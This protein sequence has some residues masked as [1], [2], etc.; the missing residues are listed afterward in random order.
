MINTKCREIISIDSIQ[1]KLYED[2]RI[3]LT[4]TFTS[5]IPVSLLGR[6]W[7]DETRYNHRTEDTDRIDSILTSRRDKNWSWGNTYRPLQHK[8]AFQDTR[9]H[10]EVPPPRW[11]TPALEWTDGGHLHFSKLSS[12][13]GEGPSLEAPVA[14]SSRPIDISDYTRLVMISNDPNDD[15]GRRLIRELTIRMIIRRRTSSWNA[16]RCSCRTQSLD[17]NDILNIYQGTI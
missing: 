4:S 13:Q 7:M 11:P 14:I 9:R 16:L 5:I 15:K 17:L 1:D 10:A 6:S 3:R 2:E 12:Y 8:P